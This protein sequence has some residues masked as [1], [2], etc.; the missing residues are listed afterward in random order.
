MVLSRRGVVIGGLALVA[1]GATG[2]IV[3]AATAKSF[4]AGDASDNNF[5]YRKTN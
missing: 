1:V 2:N 4:F 5:V 3:L